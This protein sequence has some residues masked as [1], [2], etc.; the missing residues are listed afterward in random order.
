MRSKKAKS[1][2]PKDKSGPKGKK[3][4]TKEPK[5]KGKSSTAPTPNTSETI[6]S[7]DKREEGTESKIKRLKI[8]S[9]SRPMIKEV[10]KI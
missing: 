3:P 1:R 10:V 2:A 9:K 7:P 5:A 6:V 4:K 8:S